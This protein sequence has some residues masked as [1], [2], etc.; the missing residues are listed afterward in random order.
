[1][2][3]DGTQDPDPALEDV[4]PRLQQTRTMDSR[5]MSPTPGML[6]KPAPKSAFLSPS[7]Y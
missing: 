4:F 5:G 6:R 7:R 3:L 1:L 2:P